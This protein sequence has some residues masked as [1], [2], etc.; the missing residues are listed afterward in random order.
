V[1][2]GSGRDGR[3]GA[4]SEGAF[5]GCGALA[6]FGAGPAGA[7]GGAEAQ[8]TQKAM[9]RATATQGNVLAKEGVTRTVTAA[10]GKETFIHTT[11]RAAFPH[12]AESA[13]VTI[14]E[15]KTI[16]LSTRGE[17]AHWGEGAYAYEGAIA[18]SDEVLVQ[19][20]VPKGTA[21]ERITIPGEKT[22]VRLVPA[23]G[24]VLQVVNPV[25]NLSAQQ[26]KTAAEWIQQ[27]VRPFQ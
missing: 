4:T 23:E 16:N 12:T 8:V 1:D 11:S 14:A 19:F 17:V 25:T 15:S 9:F 22:I 2:N 27:W 5:S 3:E 24:N 20:S 13:A 7:A 26:T 21:I 6:A 18:R 10:T